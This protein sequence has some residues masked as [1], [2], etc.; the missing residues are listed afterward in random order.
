ML[1]L[2]GYTIQY[3]ENQLALGSLF[4]PEDGG[5]TFHQTIS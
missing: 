2:P 5:D 3:V 1:Y 4:N